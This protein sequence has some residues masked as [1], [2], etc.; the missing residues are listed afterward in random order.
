M[1]LEQE[2]LKRGQNK[3]SIDFDLV[4]NRVFLDTNLEEGV[5]NQCGYRLTELDK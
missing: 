5:W 2:S 1:I 3:V 4:R